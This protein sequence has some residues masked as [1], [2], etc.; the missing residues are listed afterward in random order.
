MEKRKV[1][2]AILETVAQCAN[3]PFDYL[4]TLYKQGY[5]KEKRIFQFWEMA[6]YRQGKLKQKPDWMIKREKKIRDFLA[7]GMSV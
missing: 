4:N 7:G 2:K 3:I 5:L 6:M 1:T